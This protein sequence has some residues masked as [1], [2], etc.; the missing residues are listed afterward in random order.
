MC[1]RRRKSCL[2]Y[3][4]AMNE[5][6]LIKFRKDCFLRKQAGYEDKGKKNM[7]AIL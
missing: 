7:K 5:V 2:P 3:T 6:L 1:V 4:K